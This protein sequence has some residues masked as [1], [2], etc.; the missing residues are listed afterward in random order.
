MN[1]EALLPML[2]VESD[3]RALHIGRGPVLVHHFRILPVSVFQSNCRTLP[4]NPHSTPTLD[5][6]F[7]IPFHLPP[8]RAQLHHSRPSAIRV[9]FDLSLNLTSSTDS[10]SVP[11]MSTSIIVVSPDNRQWSA[12]RPAAALLQSILEDACTHFALDATTHRLEQK[13]ARGNSRSVDH[14]LS[15]RIA[16]LPANSRLHLTHCPNLSPNVHL[17]LSLPGQ[18]PAAVNAVFPVSSTLK[19]VLLHF[20]AIHPHLHLLSYAGVPPPEHNERFSLTINVT[21][22]MQAV[23]DTGCKRVTGDD[24]LANTTLAQLGFKGEEGGRVGKGRLKVSHDYQQPSLSEAQQIEAIQR[25]STTLHQSV[26]E[27][28][29]KRREKAAEQQ[30]QEAAEAAVVLPADRQLRVLQALP[31]LLPAPELPESFYEVTEDD[32]VEYARS[33]MRQ[34]AKERGEATPASAGSSGATKRDRPVVSLVR[35]KLPSHVYVEG[36]FKAGERVADVRDWLLARCIRDEIRPNI[37]PLFVTP[38]KRALD[39]RSTLRQEGL[40]GSVVLHATINGRHDTAG[41]RRGRE[42]IRE[43]E[44]KEEK[45]EKEVKEEKL[46]P[47]PS[48]AG[49]EAQHSEWLPEEFLNVDALAAMQSITPPSE[50]AETGVSNQ[51]TTESSAGEAAQQSA[52]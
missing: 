19:D 16:Q 20:R 46:P 31:V 41:V 14:T 17:T 15:I 49:V 32:S 29:Q 4:V 33:V 9:T 23:V 7:H 21:G 37:S 44:G 52:A 40:L 10:H 11:A 25:F 36:V 13:D 22:H 35:I 12:T 47:A 6:I 39:T 30:R 27:V 42:T 45:E 8:Q 2:V 34:A 5:S 51:S 18:Q 50:P 3:N 28:H 38:P 48:T 26:E 43:E 24:E 1:N